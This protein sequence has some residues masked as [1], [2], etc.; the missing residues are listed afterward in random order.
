MRPPS[1][2]GS[3]SRSIS[4]TSADSARSKPAW[5]SSRSTWPSWRERSWPPTCCRRTE[6]SGCWRSR[7]CSS[8]PASPGCPRR[9]G[10]ARSSYTSCC[11]GT[12]INLLSGAGF[13][14]VP[15]A[16][17]YSMSKASLWMLTRCFAKDCAPRIRGNG[18]C[19]G[20]ISPDGV[21]RT[22]ELRKATPMGRGGC[23]DEVVGAAIYLASE[24]SGY[25]TGDVVYVNGGI[26]GLTGYSDEIM[27]SD[28][29]GR[30][31]TGRR[32]AG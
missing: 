6:P 21:A 1:R 8:R 28:P 30:P 9:V 18:L 16:A 24:A 22:E 14:P 32:T 31:R 19:P 11:P 12:I 5:P 10:T 20:T 15:L 17:P 4:R 13:T 23:A 27:G 26:T 25:S 3:S 2:C 7:R 29:V